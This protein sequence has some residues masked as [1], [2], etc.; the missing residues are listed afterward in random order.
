MNTRWIETTQ[1]NMAKIA[2]FLKNAWNKEPVL[3]TAIA[4]GLSAI[5]LPFISPYTAY[6]GMINSAVPYSYPVPVRDDGNMPDIPAHPSEP[7]GKN[8]DWLKNL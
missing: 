5:T 2:A 4:I 3:V 8:L 6:A 7:K 1:D